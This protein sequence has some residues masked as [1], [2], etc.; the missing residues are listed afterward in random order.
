MVVVTRATIHA[1]HADAVGVMV[2]DGATRNLRQGLD[3]E[4]DPTRISKL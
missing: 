3:L 4:Q 1:T 2:A